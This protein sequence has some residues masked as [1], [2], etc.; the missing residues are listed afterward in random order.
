[1][2]FQKTSPVDLGESRRFSINTFLGFQKI[3]WDALE[4][5]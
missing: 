2:Y 5:Y 1:M 3:F 4:Y